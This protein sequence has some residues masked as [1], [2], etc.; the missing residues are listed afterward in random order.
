MSDIRGEIE[1]AKIM[2]K[3]YEERNS[4][5]QAEALKTLLSLASRVE[6]V[7]AMEEKEITYTE[8]RE[9]LG[10]W[11]GYNQALKEVKELLSK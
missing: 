10:K 3:Q 4:Y 9:Q 1:V 8:N 5:S 7:M 11:Y 2:L 6:R